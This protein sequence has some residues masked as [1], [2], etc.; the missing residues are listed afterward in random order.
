[1][2]AFR[3]ACLRKRSIHTGYNLLADDHRR[4]LC[5]ANPI[6]S[7]LGRLCDFYDFRALVAIYNIYSLHVSN[8]IKSALWIRFMDWILRSLLWPPYV[9]GQTI[10][11]CPIVSIFLLLLS[12]F[13]SSPNLS[14]RRLDVYHSSSHDAA[15]VRI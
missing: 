2:G 14:G 3:I 6:L 1:M 9:I 7:T 10:I 8:Y 4:T 12:S 11:F 5:S 15:L 13:F